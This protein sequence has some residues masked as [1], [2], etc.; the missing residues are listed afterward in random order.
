MLWNYPV[1]RNDEMFI[2]LSG[3]SDSN[4]KLLSTAS[5][6]INSNYYCL[7]LG[8]TRSFS[9]SLLPLRLQLCTN[10]PHPP[11][12]SA[13]DSNK[14]VNICSGTDCAKDTPLARGG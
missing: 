4:S 12:L 9:E 11:C 14:K 1:H 3:G 10:H 6:C 2:L 8:P 7:Q 5:N 13:E